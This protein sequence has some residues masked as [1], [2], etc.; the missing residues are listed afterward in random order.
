MG[1]LDELLQSIRD[2]AK[3]ESALTLY[4]GTRQDDLVDE[5]IDERILRL[6]GLD[7]VFD[8]D[9]ST[10]LTL[11]KEKMV[12][13]RMTDSKLSTEESEL[14]TNEFRR[15]KGKVG[16]FS[17]RKKKV[18]IGDAPENQAIKADKFLPP[19]SLTPPEPP[20]IEGAKEKQ[21]T[22]KD[23]EYLLQITET[24]KSIKDILIKRGK[25]DESIRETE[26]KRLEKEKRAERESNREKRKSGGN[27]LKKL[28][29]A[30]PSL[31]IF[32]MIKRFISNV[33]LGKAV[34]SLL[35]WIS[36]PENKKKVDAIGNFLK[37]WWP[38]LTAA[39]LMF[40]T[41]LGGFVRTM[42]SSLAG[43]TKFLLA[44]SLKLLRLAAKNPLVTAAIGVGI[45][46][47]A[48][49]MRSKDSSEQ[50][51]EDRGKAD[52]SPKEQADE[53]SKPMNIMETLTR[54][55]L[56]SLNESKVEG[57]SGGGLVG[58]SGGG[59][60]P[61]GTDTVPAMLTP[62]EF[63]MS[64]GAV[65]KFG[66]GTLMEMNKMGGGT[67]KPKVVSGASFIS[68]GGFVDG[69]TTSISNRDSNSSQRNNNITYAS[70]GGLIIGK[71]NSTFNNNPKFISGITYASGGGLIIGKNNSTFN[72][73]PKFISGITYASGGGLITRKNI[74]NFSES[75]NSSQRNNNITY[76][77]GG[78]LVDAF[79]FLPGTGTVMAPRASQ[80]QYA[81]QGTTVQKFLGMTIPG[82]MKRSKYTPEDIQR[83]NRL[84]TGD[85][86]RYLESYDA[87]D[88]R[89]ESINKIYAK[90]GQIPTSKAV[91]SKN[92][93]VPNTPTPQM[94]EKERNDRFIG[95]SFK[96]FGSNVETIK[97]RNQKM[98]EQMAELGIRPDGYVNPFG[99]PVTADGKPIKR[100]GYNGGGIVSS[101]NNINYFSGGGFS[102]RG[103]DTVPAMLTP[104]EFVMS[105]GAVNKFGT[106]TMMKMNKAGG[107]TNKPKV[108]SGTSF[109]SGGG[110][111][112]SAPQ[113][114][115]ISDAD[116]AILL[117]ITALEDTDAQG[118]AD[119][120]Q[121]LYNRLHSVNAYGG[122]YNQLNNTLKSIITA[123]SEM[124]AMGGG[125][126]Q[127][128]FGNPQDWK[129]ITDKKS[130]AI[131]IMNSEKGRRYG[132]TMETAMQQILDTEKAL[133]NPDLQQKAREHVEGRT[134]FLGKSQQ[135]NMQPGDVLRGPDRNFFSM[136]YDEKTQYGKERANIASPMPQR[137]IPPPAQ[138]IP[139]PSETKVTP[140]KAGPKGLIQSLTDEQ[141]MSGFYMKPINAILGNNSSKDLSID[142]N[143]RPNIPEPPSRSS[144]TN[145]INLPPIDMGGGRSP[146][147]ETTP[148]TG[149]QE[150]QFPTV[151]KMASKTRAR[152]IDTYGVLR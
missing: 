72:N 145:T 35:Q 37:D 69:R 108:I 81:D 127:P 70:G 94:S 73:N 95:E 5:E 128:T 75:N 13:A 131:A 144:K 111:A 51:L 101:S 103:T 148:F 122:N 16:R 26:R 132:Y 92:R 113:G 90:Y 19:S 39:F 58:F 152:K 57:R 119:V 135:Q 9:Y 104:G 2:E 34:F 32:D 91:I 78:G 6:L 60:S 62:G 147:Q 138:I 133:S 107:G 116:A 61:L 67:N 97:T 47:A 10:Y 106:S 88:T 139:K 141:G 24:L 150:P 146:Y 43:L 115:K 100:K 68:E 59:M 49:A 11:L 28:K 55:M 8:I 52:A 142:K 89:T 46:A 126:Y 82:S 65:D 130:A 17:I 41:P 120:A 30:V 149:S 124:G 77:S 1:D 71:N 80:G 93:E 56:P 15:V 29:G 121:S 109:L 66:S 63:V 123:K 83:Y 125:Q 117:A 114:P 74:N 99:A 98:V 53:L 84:D 4:E 18:N 33:L 12:A 118:R 79:S 134:Y 136:W 129:N 40:V 27:F 102:P 31:G 7:E 110:P 112:K 20:Q 137:F 140:Q 44:Q 105:K 64:K 87:Q 36:D 14:L 42:V 151:S 76:A 3:R 38:A 21:K 86:S 54:T 48:L 25:V 96:N 23:L 45:G 85:P 50:I 143:V 22:S